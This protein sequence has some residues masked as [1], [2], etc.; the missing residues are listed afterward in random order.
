M[1]LSKQK[2]IAARFNKILEEGVVPWK[3]HSPEPNLKEFLKL[4]KREKAKI[5]EH[6]PEGLLRLIIVSPEVFIELNSKPIQEDLWVITNTNDGEKTIFY[7]P[8][9][10]SG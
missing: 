10:T 4:L 2:Q 7:A 5:L 1:E 6:I 3:S 9:F 8:S